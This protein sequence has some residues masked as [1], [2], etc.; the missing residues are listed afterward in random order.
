MVQSIVVSS[1]ALALLG[2]FLGIAAK[3]FLPYIRKTIVE[4]KPLQWQHKFSGILI[5]SVILTVVVFP[6]FSPPANGFNI[7][8]A[9]FSF[10]LAVEWSIVEGYQWIKSYTMRREGGSPND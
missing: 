1:E 9:A 4:N 6:Q 3:A 2:M 8:V 5:L 7:F 10:G